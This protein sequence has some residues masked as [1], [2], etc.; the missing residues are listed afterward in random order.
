MSQR[1][2][3]CVA[4]AVCL[5]LRVELLFLSMPDWFSTYMV[6]FGFGRQSF[7]CCDSLLC[8][9]SKHEAT[10]VASHKQSF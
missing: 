8:S 2:K 4:V 1:G 7:M 3:H 10:S 5:V 9:A 6:G